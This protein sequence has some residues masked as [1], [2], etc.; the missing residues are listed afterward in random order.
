MVSFFDGNWL[1]YTEYFF[2]K[3]IFYL[4]LGLRN[5][6]MII[7][8]LLGSFR[9]KKFLNRIPPRMEQLRHISFDRNL[10]KK[11]KLKLVVL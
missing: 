1:A 3:S 5:I 11:S 2:N 6:M 10:F 7:S 4:C 9:V 8:S